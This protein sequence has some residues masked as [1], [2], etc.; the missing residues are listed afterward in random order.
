MERTKS[1]WH[2]LIIQDKETITQLSYIIYNTL[3]SRSFDKNIID[4]STLIFYGYDV[5]VSKQ[6]ERRLGQ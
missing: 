5:T 4:A 6:T 2:Q 1:L 3:W